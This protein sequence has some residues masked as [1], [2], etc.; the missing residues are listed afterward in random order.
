MYIFTGVKSRYES[1]FL[2]IY[3]KKR[4][5]FLIL[6]FLSYTMCKDLNKNL[7]LFAMNE[8]NKIFKNF[9]IHMKSLISLFINLLLL[10]KIIYL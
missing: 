1:N 10:K 2:K 6:F 9:V 5:S 8:V 7:I 4:I 3:L